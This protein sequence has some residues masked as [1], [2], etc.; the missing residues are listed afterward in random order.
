MGCVS[1]RKVNDSV[2]VPPVDNASNSA[3]RE[4]VALLI[5]RLPKAEAREKLK[6]ALDRRLKGSGSAPQKKSGG[7]LFGLFGS[8]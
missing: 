6:V 1:S 4:K 2:M 8:R 7:G 3:P 5:A